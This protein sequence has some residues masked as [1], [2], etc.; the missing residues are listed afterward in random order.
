MCGIM[1]YYCF[2]NNKP[3]IEKLADMFCLL[4]SRGTDA[5]GLS[6]IKPDGSLYIHKAP[7]RSSHLIKTDE[8]K[9]I[10]MPPVMIMHCR[11]KTQGT[12]KNNANN[13]PLFSKNGIALVHNGIIYNDKEIFSKK[14]RDAEV[15]SEA[16]LSLL[17]SKHKGDKIR[18]LFDRIEG[19][20]AVAAI[21]KSEPGK[22]LLIKK[23]NPVDLYFD[24][25]NDILYFC[26][27]RQ[28]MQEALGVK[29][30]S[31]RGFNLGEGSYH[32]Y[33]M[34]NNHALIINQDGV[35][36]YKRYRPKID[37]WVSIKDTRP[38]GFT[39]DMVECPWCYTQ[40]IFDF[41]RQNNDC[42]YCGHPIY[43]EDVYV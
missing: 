42:E 23:D 22:L 25:E 10:E 43:E 39:A 18:L 41:N 40:T 11:L 37:D 8:W 15:D 28:I 5:S 33:E 29:G 9:N 17:S 27:E 19:S 26:S 16:I 36:S 38:Y 1:G 7:T 4:Q 2:S 35:Q 30:K 34:E 32:F 13:H 14:N 31:K 6:F 20:F 24:S 12:E 21:N 3:D